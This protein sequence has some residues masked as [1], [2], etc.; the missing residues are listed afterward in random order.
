MK[1]NGDV[2]LITE[3][4]ETANLIRNF[5]FSK[6]A[7]I[8]DEVLA[9]GGV[10]ISGEGSSRILPAKNFITEAYRRGIDLSMGT[11]GSYQACEY[12][13]SRHVVLVSSNSGQTKETIALVRKLLAEGHEDVYAVTATPGSILDQEASASILLTCGVEKAV[14][15]TKSVVEQ[16]L[17]YQS[18]LCNMT[19]LTSCESNKIK[20]AVLAENVM[21]ASYDP[22]L[23]AHLAQCDRLFFA[24]R[25]DGVAEELALKATEI[26]RKPSMFLE[27]T[28]AL[29]GFEEIMSPRDVLVFVEPFASE[30]DKMKEIFVDGVGAKVVALSSTPTPFSTIH[31]PLLDG[32]SNYLALMAGWNL[33]VHVGQQLG[34]NLD[35]P[36]RARKIGN[37]I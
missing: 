33:L 27:G 11:E 19:P 14:A 4:M 28:I 6:T 37:A 16:A 15:A 36:N 25:N 2:A 12:D 3:M 18:I 31:L 30:H 22:D 34:L 5:D 17:I 9:A 1:N 26:T 10:F 21:A 32:F 7:G 13:L 8:A 23:V 24:G 29:H 35:K 20:A